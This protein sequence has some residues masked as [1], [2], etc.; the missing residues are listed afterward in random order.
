MKREAN[1][2]TLFG[3][4][5][6]KKK[7][8]G[9][10]ELKQ[11]TTSSLPVTIKGT[12]KRQT[13][14]LVTAQESGLFWKHS[15][16]DPREKPCDCSFI[17]PVDGYMVIKYPGQFSIINVYDFI[18]ESKRVKSLTKKRAEEIAITTVYL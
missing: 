18:S 7:L 4:Y 15:D 5:V 10:F 8:Y 11:T 14:S 17:P 16:A 6:R 2:Q 1:F 12:L 9:N 13:E 3:Q